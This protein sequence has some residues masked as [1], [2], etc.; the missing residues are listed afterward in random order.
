[1]NYLVIGGSGFIGSNIMERLKKEKKNDDT[2]TRFD[3][4]DILYF[5]ARN[6]KRMEDYTKGTGIVIHCGNIPAHRLSMDDP[7]TIIENNY[8]ATLGVLEACRRTDCRKIVFLSSFAV[9]GKHNPLPWTEKTPLCCSNTPY[10]ACKIH[11]EEL[12]M[13]YHEWYG[14]D[15]III[16]PSNVFGENEKLHLPLQVIPQWFLD[17]EEGRPLVVN[18]AHTVRDFTYV[19]DIVRGILLASK[20][21]GYEIY[22]L[23]SGVPVYLLDI[24]YKISDKVQL[25]SIPDYETE[26][27]YGSCEKAKTE[28]G[29]VNTKTIWEWIDERKHTD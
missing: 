24:A 6:E 11:S 23:C 14:L 13:Y 28:L 12:L 4:R 19:Q 9:Y 18:G 25:K 16:R 21:G 2:V 20:K 3:I 17:A 29:F 1:M 26:D 22:N 10:G 7:Y 27:W 15:I 5:D 8:N